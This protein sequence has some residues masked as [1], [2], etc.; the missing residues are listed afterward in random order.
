MDSE[1]D[2]GFAEVNRDDDNDD[3]NDSNSPRRGRDGPETALDRHIFR[4]SIQSIKQRVAFN[5]YKNPL[6]HFTAVLGWDGVKRMWNP[7][8]GAITAKFAGLLWCCR[9]LMLEHIFGD[10]LGID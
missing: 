1:S 7:D 4:F 9:L 10:E 5:L 8:V 6:I 2:F 3:D